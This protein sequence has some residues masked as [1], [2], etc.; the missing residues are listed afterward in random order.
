ML[1]YGSYVQLYSYIWVNYNISLTWI[2]AIW[3]SFPL[4]TMIIVRSQWGR[5]NLPRWNMTYRVKPFWSHWSHPAFHFFDTPNPWIRGWDFPLRSSGLDLWRPQ[6][7]LPELLVP[8]LLLGSDR[9]WRKRNRAHA[10]SRHGQLAARW[11][12]RVVLLTKV[13]S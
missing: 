3:G 7:L 9:S 13:I 11:Y 6:L 5:Y 8:T 4:L 1:C 10:F 12:V 2:K